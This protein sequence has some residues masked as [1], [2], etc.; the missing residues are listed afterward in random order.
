MFADEK[1]GED[2]REDELAEAPDEVGAV[3]SILSDAKG[4]ADDDVNFA[5]VDE[6]FLE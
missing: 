5:G 2:V 6:F 1:A 3:A 4:A